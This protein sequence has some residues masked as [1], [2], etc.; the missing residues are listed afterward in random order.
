MK[1]VRIEIN[2]VEGRRT[3]Q[4]I[5]QI[6]FWFLRDKP[7]SQTKQKREETEMNAIRDK[8][9]TIITITEEIH[10]LIMTYPK[11]IY[12]IELENVKEMD[13]L[14]DAYDLP[15]L[16]QDESNNLNRSITSNNIGIGIE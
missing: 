13:E 4:R 1:K 7:F 11:N 14:L 12:Y 5:Y 6:K 3:A 2:K 10:K 9:R 15:K 8:I 16:N